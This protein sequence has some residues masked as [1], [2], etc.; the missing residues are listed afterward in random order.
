M[1][2]L[3]SMLLVL[4]MLLSMGTVFAAGEEKI[5]EPQERYYSAE[6][7]EV[8]KVL[9]RLYEM[10]LET[11]E[12]PRPTIAKTNLEN[13]IR[14]N[15]LTEKEAFDEEILTWIKERIDFLNEENYEIKLKDKKEINSILDEIE[16]R[17]IKLPRDYNIKLNSLKKELSKLEKIEEETKEDERLD[18]L[19]RRAPRLVNLA[20]KNK[21]AEDYK[22][23]YD[24]IIQLN[25]KS[26]QEEVKGWMARLDILKAQME[27][28]AAEETQL[29]LDKFLTSRNLVTSKWSKEHIVKAGKLE[30]LNGT[31]LY[32]N[33]DLTTDITRGDF[34]ELMMNYMNKTVSAE[35]LNLIRFNAE[36]VY[37][38]DIDIKTQSSIIEATQL[39]LIFGMGNDKFAPED[40]INRE[41]IA[42]IV[43]RAMKIVNLN[44]IDTRQDVELAIFSDKNDIA[45]WARQGVANMTTVRAI[46]GNG[47]GMFVPKGYTTKEQAIKIIVE[48]MK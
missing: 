19:L 15:K 16:F 7:Y 28:K 32:K 21:T 47:M 6:D 13:F 46:E 26:E 12:T 20:E 31:R 33:S 5:V 35:R 29:A 44:F 24:T 9:Y 36:A 10:E 25:R 23:A 48:L 45:A 17:G 1:K 8:V 14:R 39:G 34:V 38:D 18:K 41:Q 37:Y 3:I 27:N 42:V 40:V 2:R 4:V 43:N 11:P 30:L 22:T